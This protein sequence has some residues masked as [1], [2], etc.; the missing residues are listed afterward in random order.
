MPQFLDSA[1]R[2]L[3]VAI[4]AGAVDAIVVKQFTNLSRNHEDIRKLL[5]LFDR[6]GITI[7]E[8]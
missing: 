5:E 8:L 6:A 7:Y 4:E 2:E 1:L 3:I